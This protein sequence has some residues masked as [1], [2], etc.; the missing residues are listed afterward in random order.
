LK[1]KSLPLNLFIST[2]E[3]SSFLC[4]GFFAVKKK[5]VKPCI[6]DKIL[7]VI[8]KIIKQLDKIISETIYHKITIPIYNKGEKI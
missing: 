4:I 5:K 2:E 1:F 8:Y 3:K 6:K 7:F